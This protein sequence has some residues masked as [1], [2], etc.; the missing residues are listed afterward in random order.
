MENETLSIFTSLILPIIQSL[1][2]PSAVVITSIITS[3]N[4]QAVAALKEQIRSLNEQMRLLN[5]IPLT[6]KDDG[7]FYTQ[8]GIPFCSACFAKGHKVPLRKNPD[9]KN[10]GYDC[11]VFTSCNAFYYPKYARQV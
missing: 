7:V 1:S 4:N 9:S 3:K 6:L 5:E 2:I 10:G 11:P 8:N